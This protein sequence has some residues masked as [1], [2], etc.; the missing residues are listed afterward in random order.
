MEFK[1]DQEILR[2]EILRYQ[3]Y[4]HVRDNYDFPGCPLCYNG[5]SFLFDDGEQDLIEDENRIKNLEA[6]LR[7]P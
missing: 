3:H 4:T 5:P 2:L 6:R 7:A 1:F